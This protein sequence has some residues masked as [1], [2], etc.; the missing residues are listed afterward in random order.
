MPILKGKMGEFSALK[1]LSKEVKNALTPLIDIPRI[2]LEYSYE[3]PPKQ[4]Y[5]LEV[6]LEKIATKIGSNWG[7]IDYCFVDLFDIRL[8]ERT[9]SGEHP[10]TCISKNL[11]NEGVKSILTTGLDRDN[12]YNNCLAQILSD[13]AGEVCIRLIDDDLDLI[14]DLEDELDFLMAVLSVTPENVHLLLDFRVVRVDKIQETISKAT[15]LINKSK[16]ISNWKNI[17]IAGSGFPG[18]LSQI[19]KNTAQFFPRVEFKIWMFLLKNRKRLKRV[20]VFGDY[21]VVYPNTPTLDPRIINP[22]ARIRYTYNDAWLILKGH[23]LKVPPKY[24]Q[25]HSLSS[26]LI[27]RDEFQGR[28]YCWGDQYIEDCAAMMVT[29]G[30]LQKWVTIDTNHHLTFV[31]DQIASFDG[32]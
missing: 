3:E 15:A 1:H 32:S 6:H 13:S 30:N 14:D 11:Q 9:S 31:T 4:K 12:N 16:N 17:I 10:L 18:S 21:G 7:T 24:K 23:S 28:N 19:K 20:P 25:Y 29:S 8:S 22:S 26:K 5:P 27:V 2:P